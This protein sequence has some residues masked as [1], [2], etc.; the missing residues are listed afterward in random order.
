MEKSADSSG[1]NDEFPPEK[2]LEAPNHRLIKAGIATIPDMET[3]R[4]CV[5]YENAHQNRTQILRRLQWKAEEL[6][7]DE[8]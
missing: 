4:E 8:T 6:R 2:R 7:E 1:N 5:A 3:L